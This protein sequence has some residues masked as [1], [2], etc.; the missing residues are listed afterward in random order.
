MSKS[1]RENLPRVNFFDGQRVT[2]TDLDVEQIHHR[3]IASNIIVD[4]HKSGVVR[5]RIFDS[6]ILLDTS[7]PSTYSADGSENI[8]KEIIESGR[9]DGRAINVDRQPSDTVYGNRLEVSSE[10]LSVGGRVRLKVL[11]LGLKYSS[12]KTG[13]EL[14]FE[15]IEF[16]KNQTKLSRNYF[17]K[18]ISVFFN[19]FSGGFG[20]TDISAGKNSKITLGDSGRVVIKEAEPLKVFSRTPVFEQIESPNVGISRFISSSTSL[21]IEDEIRKALGT[22]YNFNELYLETEVAKDLLF[23]PYADQTI[24]YGQKF[25]ATTD[26]IQKIDILLYVNRDDEAAIG[27]EY[28]FS[29]ELVFSIHKLK[30]LITR[31]SNQ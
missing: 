10:G 28:N 20:K 31:Q 8:S 14:C 6:K 15:I 16:D 5:D 17:T 1:S 3:N 11:I 2:E 29:G 4:F 24:S 19:N 30:T 13:G 9:Y 18:V 22:R 23:E 26:N 12:I 27:S 21:S 25:L 7:A